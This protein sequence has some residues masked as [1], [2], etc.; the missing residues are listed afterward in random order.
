MG[1]D[2]ESSF[3]DIQEDLVFVL[4]IVFGISRILRFF[5]N[6]NPPYL[7]L[8]HLSCVCI[9]LLFPF[10]VENDAYCIVSCLYSLVFLVSC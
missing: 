10:I 6:C 2:L 4:N 3:R 8:L 1:Y 5:L 9:S 7:I